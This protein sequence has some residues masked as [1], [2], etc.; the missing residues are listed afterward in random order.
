MIMITVTK[1]KNNSIIGFMEIIT[2]NDKIHD[3]IKKTLI[4]K[5]KPKNVTY[6]IQT[7]K[8]PLRLICSANIT[9]IKTKGNM[10]S[11]YDTSIIPFALKIPP[12]Q[13][14]QLLL[15][16]SRKSRYGYSQDIFG[17]SVSG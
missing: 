15:P 11:I 14:C 5:K 4:L 1:I 12:F 16:P 9:F 10:S 13:H 3:S 17:E 7:M 8:R 2:I 6:S